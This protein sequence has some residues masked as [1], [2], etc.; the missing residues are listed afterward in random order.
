VEAHGDLLSIGSTVEG[1]RSAS[2]ITTSARSSALAQ[3]V[4]LALAQPSVGD[5]PQVAVY[6]L[7]E[8]ADG[9]VVAAASAFEKTAEVGCFFGHGGSV[10]ASARPDKCQRARSTIEIAD[11][12]LADAQ[13]GHPGRRGSA[14]SGEALNPAYFKAHLEARFLG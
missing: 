5:A 9:G 8:R 14:A 3:R 6:P 13:R 10:P 7:E 1:T 12:L 2:P 4:A 11:R